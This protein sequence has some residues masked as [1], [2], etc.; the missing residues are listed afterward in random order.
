[1]TYELLTTGRG[2]MT[3][4]TPILQDVRDTYAVS[5]VL[6]ESGV[7]IALLKGADGVEYRKAITYGTADKGYVIGECKVP[8][9]LLKQEQYVSLVVS[10][11]NGEKVLRSWECEPLKITAFLYLRQTQWQVSG[12]M[13]DKD[14]YDRMVELEHLYAQSLADFGALNAAVEGYKT[15]T[16][17]LVAELQAEQKRLTETVASVKKNNETLT[18]AYNE[19]SKVVNDLSNR[20]SALEKNYDPTIIE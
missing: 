5:F 10:E 14:A 15:E 7:Y 11:I 18:N 1:M 16:A 3:D 4:R 2:V 13:T 17:A 9:E 8:K 20:L 19:A 12:G 6:P